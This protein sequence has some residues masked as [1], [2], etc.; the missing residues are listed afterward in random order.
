MKSHDI[1]KKLEKSWA[2]KTN[3]KQGRL[4][5]YRSHRKGI[6]L[7]LEYGIKK[8]KSIRKIVETKLSEISSQKELKNLI[9]WVAEQ[10]YSHKY[11]YC[12]NLSFKIITK[13]TPIGK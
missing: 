4:K 2:K 13:Q 8:A 10:F 1:G 7:E 12:L 5:G 9:K 11:L 6:L 3:S